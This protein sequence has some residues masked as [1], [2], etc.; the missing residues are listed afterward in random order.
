ML[1]PWHGPECLLGTHIGEQSE[2]G[3]KTTTLPKGQETSKEVCLGDQLT[4]EQ[5]EHLRLLINEFGDVFNEIPGCA[6]GIE[7]KII[8]PE[9]RVVREKWRRIPYHPYDVI[10]TEID[11]VLA[12]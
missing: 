10:K 6:K 12:L 9:G 1:K 11:K 4:I 5:Q 7:H 8:A 3:N 2:S